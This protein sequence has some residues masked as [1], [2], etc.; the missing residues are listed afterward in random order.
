MRAQ[1]IVQ[2][3]GLLLCKHENLNLDHQKPCNKKKKE[4]VPITSALRDRDRRISGTHGLVEMVNLRL[5][6]RP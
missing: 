3:I 4:H 2:W 1:R 6:E 5:S